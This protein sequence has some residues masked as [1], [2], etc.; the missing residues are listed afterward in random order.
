MPDYCTAEQT[1]NCVPQQQ[2]VVRQHQFGSNSAR[3]ERLQG[4]SGTQSQN[5][6]GAG[7]VVLGSLAPVNLPEI[8]YTVQ[9]LEGTAVDVQN[10]KTPSPS[11]AVSVLTGLAS[12]F[13]E[14][15]TLRDRLNAALS[16]LPEDYSEGLEGMEM[17]VDGPNPSSK[18]VHI[19][20]RF[21]FSDRDVLEARLKAARKY[22]VW[23]KRN[24]KTVVTTAKAVRKLRDSLQD[25]LTTPG[26]AIP[27]FGTVIAS[28]W[29]DLDLSWVPMTAEIA[30]TAQKL[31]TRSD[32]TVLN[33][34]AALKRY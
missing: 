26:V 4:Q 32:E 19:D 2:A 18:S 27:P 17:Y 1:E 6:V 3:Q 24:L 25:F 29:L 15:K 9:A 31:K 33:I 21:G 28:H 11:D 8:V 23:L 7:L 12:R 5:R 30:S 13:D 34:S 14:L 22:Q 20:D 10:G 16:S